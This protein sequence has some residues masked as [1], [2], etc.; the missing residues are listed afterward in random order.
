MHE[1]DKLD[2]A[3]H[4]LERMAQSPEPKTFRFELSA[5]LSAAR[6]ALQYA[7]EEAK[8]KAGGQRWYDEQVSRKAMVK[9]FKDKRDISIHC[10]PVIPTTTA[11]IAV[12]E[13][14]GF[15]EALHLQVING[16][17][18]I[19][20]DAS[21]SGEP[22]TPPPPQPAVVT[23]TYTFADWSGPEDLLALSSRY[24]VEAQSIVNAGVA[25]GYLTR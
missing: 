17:G 19:I 10:Q 9:F 18:K 1:Q 3:Q 7:L 8:S 25:K 14:V 12:T 24:F 16:D 23:Y 13:R 2:E 11:S 15:S 5:F 20:Q 22:N 4:F 21:V 6:S